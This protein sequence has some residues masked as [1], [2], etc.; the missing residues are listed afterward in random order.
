MMG[1]VE[2]RELKFEWREGSRGVD[3]LKIVGENGAFTFEPDISRGF[4][5]VEHPFDREAALNV[6]K[7]LSEAIL[8]RLTKG[9]HTHGT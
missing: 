5:T 7:S 6:V 3:S 4:N 2:V 8:E 1:G 9:H